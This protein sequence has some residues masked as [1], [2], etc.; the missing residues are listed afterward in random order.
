MSA[1]V[2]KFIGLVAILAFLTF[3]VV[4]VISLGAFIPEHW[5]AQLAFYG[6]AGLAWGFPLFPL[7]TWMNSGR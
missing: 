6:V 1:R 2:R 3:Y 7:I 5:G 4:A